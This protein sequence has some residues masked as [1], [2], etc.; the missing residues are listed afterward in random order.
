M[1]KESNEWLNVSLNHLYGP[2]FPDS[3]RTFFQTLTAK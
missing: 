2:W 1:N 3:L